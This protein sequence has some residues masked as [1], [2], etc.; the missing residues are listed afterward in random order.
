MKQSATVLYIEDDPDMIELMTMA[1]KHRG[2]QVIGALGGE[3]GWEAMQTK[4]PDVVILDLMMP[5][6]DGW[7]ILRRRREDPHLIEIPVIVATARSQK[8]DRAQ[9][10]FL[11][12]ADDY[13][14]KPF[15]IVELVER[16]EA[17]L[18]KQ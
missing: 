12:K 1:L 11:G 9:A 14:V 8:A 5:G 17:I 6:V 2:F 18:G 16:I 4:S 10:T 15:S 7:E 3:A 13:I